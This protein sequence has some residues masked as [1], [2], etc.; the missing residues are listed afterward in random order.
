MFCFQVSYTVPVT[1]SIFPVCVTLPMQYWK[2][3]VWLLAE[4]SPGVSSHFQFFSLTYLTCPACGSHSPND[5]ISSFFFWPLIFCA[6]WQ[7]P[8]VCPL[9]CC[10]FLPR[11]GPWLCSVNSFSQSSHP[12]TYS[13]FCKFLHLQL[14]DD[15]TITYLACYFNPGCFQYDF[16]LWSLNIGGLSCDFSF[17]L[18]CLNNSEFIYRIFNLYCLLLPETESY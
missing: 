14:H 12:S 17:P 10:S 9:S 4:S 5:T 18:L 7:P 15:L 11:R 8:F 13:N 6:S 1:H 2:C 3:L 16:I